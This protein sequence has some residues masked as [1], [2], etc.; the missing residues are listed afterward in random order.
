MTS[1]STKVEKLHAVLSDGKWHSTRELARRIGHTFGGAKYRL[2]QFGYRIER[3]PHPKKRWQW[4]Y[5]LLDAPENN[6][7][8]QRR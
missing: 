1:H 3:E 6:T 7:N 5:R 4:R 2:A 8:R